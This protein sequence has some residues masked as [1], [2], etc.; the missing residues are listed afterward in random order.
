MKK[1]GV[2]AIIFVLALCVC[3]LE[4][5]DFVYDADAL[6][7]D[8]TSYLI[9]ERNYASGV[10]Q[11]SLTSFTDSR[12]G[13]IISPYELDDSL[14]VFE[15]PSDLTSF[16]QTRV[17]DPLEYIHIPASVK[18]IKFGFLGNDAALECITFEQGS[19]LEKIEERAFANM[20]IQRIEIPANLE[21]LNLAAFDGCT[22][23]KIISFE[24]GSH[25]KTLVNELS[26]S[27]NG[28]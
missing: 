20:P 7:D 28:S 9:P 6:L 17:C 5:C 10:V 13:L 21:V 19:Q 27:I 15:M 8:I 24:S 3:M 14:L 25:L 23:L 26:P 16:D 4:S 18:I 11:S 12:R 2:L 22:E 1:I